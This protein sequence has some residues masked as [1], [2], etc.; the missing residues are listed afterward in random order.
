M[1]QKR[2]NMN[3]EKDGNSQPNTLALLDLGAMVAQR[4]KRGTRSI[5]HKNRQES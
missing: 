4:S 5:I 1:H 2:G 3:A